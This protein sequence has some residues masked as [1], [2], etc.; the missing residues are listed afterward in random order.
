[1]KYWIAFC[2]GF[3]LI[4]ALSWCAHAQTYMVASYGVE[5]HHAH[6][7]HSRERRALARTK[8][9]RFAIPLPRPN[10]LDAPRPGA[11]FAEA[12]ELHTLMFGFP[13]LVHR[14]ADW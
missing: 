6:H 1:L 2:L 10:P 9:A 3:A 5:T 4:L 13:P 12:I 8:G 14:G 7:H 11:Y